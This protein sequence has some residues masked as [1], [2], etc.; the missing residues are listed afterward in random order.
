MYFSFPSRSCVDPAQ[1]QRE[2]KQAEEEEMM[3]I[4]LALVVGWHWSVGQWKQHEATIKRN[5][6]G[7]MQESTATELTATFE[8]IKQATKRAM[9]ERLSEMRKT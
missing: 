1:Q 4:G 5:T 9:W 8:Q 6:N 3:K 2:E 7:T